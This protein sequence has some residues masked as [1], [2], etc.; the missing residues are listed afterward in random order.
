MSVPTELA[1]QIVDPGAY[2]NWDRSH[3]AFAELRRSNPLALVEPD[4]YAP[5]WAATKYDDIRLIETQKDAFVIGTNSFVLEKKGERSAMA[6]RALPMMDDPEHRKY[7]GVIRDWFSPAKVMKLESDVRRIAR[8]YVDR[9]I[10]PGR[11]V[12]FAAV[13]AF[14]PLN[15]VLGISGIPGGDD[16]L[17]LGMVQ[18][19]LQ[20]S[21]NTA[22]GPTFE[23]FIA[24]FQQLVDSRRK[25][26][27]EDLAS[28]L[29]NGRVDGELIGP[30]ELLGFF[31]ALLTAGHETTT[32]T[33]AGA[34]WALAERPELLDRL[35]S[36]PAALGR[37][38]EEAIRWETP[39]KHFMRTATEDLSVR[40]EKISKGDQVMLCYPS[41]NR[42]EDKFEAPFNFDID[43]KSSDGV[44]HAGFGFGPHNC[45]GQ[46]LARLEVRVFWEELLP[47]VRS[48][49]LAGSPIRNA[50]N[51]VC[52]PTS[53]PIRVTPV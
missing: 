53:V 10:G 25:N 28:A 6:L 18:G 20:S 49:E 43:R 9:L 23:N 1:N 14:Y 42:D 45:V 16:A 12:D 3:G 39:V 15:V 33:I 36:D 21:S 29:A 11:E 37:F 46:H 4:G 51:L 7:R 24:Y 35:K 8:N 31:A 47:R 19:L 17:L 26:P 22:S 44:R 2:A 52:G 38:V 5:F 40:G 27:R 34:G 41:G 50:S 32:F 13:T 48:L 30:K